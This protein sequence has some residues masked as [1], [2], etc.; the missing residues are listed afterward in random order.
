MATKTISI[1]LEAYRRL[2]R[3][4]TRPGESFSQV[5]KRAEWQPASSTGAA[6]LAILEDSPVVS[7]ASLKRLEAAQ[8]NDIPPVDAWNE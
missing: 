6:L 4:R 1:D 8:L 3:A 5:I 2:C 7:A